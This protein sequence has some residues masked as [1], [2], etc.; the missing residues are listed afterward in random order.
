MESLPIFP[1]GFN[2]RSL[3]RSSCLMIRIPFQFVAFSGA[4]LILAGCN[5]A[6]R[7]EQLSADCALTVAQNALGARDNER[8]SRLYHMAL[9]LEALVGRPGPKAQAFEAL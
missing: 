8:A 7:P 6:P 5:S 4:R 9:G 1:P 2:G 3:M